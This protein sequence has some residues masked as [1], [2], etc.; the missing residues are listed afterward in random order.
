MLH[1]TSPAHSET[2]LITNKQFSV[3]GRQL[4]AEVWGQF[5]PTRLLYFMPE[6]DINIQSPA[7]SLWL[8]GVPLILLLSQHT[9]KHTQQPD[10]D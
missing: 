4:S 9:H 7:Q 6:M 10:I 3:K 8:S 2:N 5:N 1:Y